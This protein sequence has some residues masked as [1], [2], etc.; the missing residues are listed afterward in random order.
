[1]SAVTEAAQQA[2]LDIYDPV[3]PSKFD[4]VYRVGETTCGRLLTGKRLRITL[5]GTENVPG[6]VADADILPYRH[7]VLGTLHSGFWQNIP[8]LLARLTPDIDVLR[9]AVPDLEI[10]VTGHSKG[11]GEGA[12]LAGALH[13]AAY[14]VVQVYLFAC[15]NAGFQSFANYMQ[16]NIPGVSYRNAPHGIEIF[17]DPV[18][19][20]PEPPYEPPYAHT[21]VC[22]APPGFERLLNVAW[23]KGYLYV[24]ATAL[25]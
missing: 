13:A 20:V 21:Y 10:E 1:M 12:Q 19:M 4:K 9:Q 11:A 3:D 22:E 24:K 6:W 18:P 25:L 17:G 2:C 8:A 16:S 5:Q 14:N 15:P 23:H 7:A